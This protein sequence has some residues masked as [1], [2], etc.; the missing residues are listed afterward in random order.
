MEKTTNKKM[1]IKYM[2]DLIYGKNLLSYD[3]KQS[4]EEY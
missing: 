1:L 4:W 3:D 2:V